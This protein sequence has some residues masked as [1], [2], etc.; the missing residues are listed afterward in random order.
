MAGTA[1]APRGSVCNL[2]TSRLARLQ[3][4]KVARAFRG[5]H[6]LREESPQAARAGNTRLQPTQWL[7]K[8]SE[9]GGAGHACAHAH[10]PGRAGRGLQWEEGVGGE[11][12]YTP[13]EP[14]YH[15]FLCFPEMLQRGH[16]LSGHHEILHSDRPPSS[17]RARSRG[18]PENARWKSESKGSAGR[19][20]RIGRSQMLAAA[21][22]AR[23]GRR[24]G[25][26]GGR[27]LQPASPGVCM[28]VC[29]QLI[30]CLFQG[31]KQLVKTQH[32]PGLLP[33]SKELHVNK[34]LFAAPPHGR[35]DAGARRA[36]APCDRLQP[37]SA[38]LTQG[39]GVPGRQLAV[40]D[41]V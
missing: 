14:S 13:T 32:S 23:G 5:P 29:L 3:R 16:L 12:Q 36:Q 4:T 18:Q 34:G 28:C 15:F 26:A 25:G 7:R 39:S 20:C 22:A 31:G 17:A 8:A 1:A 2:Q 9:V 6:V 33:R 35:L 21:A 37:G 38:D 19:R 11:E 27:S 41:T 40:R 24:A 10:P 30:R